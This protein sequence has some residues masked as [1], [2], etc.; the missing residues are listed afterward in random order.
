M[1]SISQSLS[2]SL[3][4]QRFRQAAAPPTAGAPPA[5]PAHT[6]LAEAVCGFWGAFG[7]DACAAALLVA[8]L[9]AANGLSLAYLALMPLASPGPRVSARMH[10]YV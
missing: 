6:A 3:T 8:A 10:V 5:P 9:V 1:I 4:H 7:S 2:H